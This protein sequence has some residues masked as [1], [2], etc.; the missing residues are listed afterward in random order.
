[1]ARSRK[2][3]LERL[4]RRLDQIHDEYNKREYVNPD[5]LYFLYSY[6][7]PADREVV[8]LIAACLAYGRVEMIM[9]TVAS[10][11]EAMGPSPSAWLEG[12]TREEMD[13]VFDGFCYRFARQEHLTALL[14]GIRDVRERWGSMEACL[15]AG[16]DPGDETIL[17]GLS[18]LTRALDPQGETGHLLAD[19]SK[20]SACKRSHLFLR[21][22]VRKDG[23]DPG[24]WE[25]VDPS[26][27]I[28]PLDT[29]MFK[30]GTFL[31]FTE[32][33]SP[34]RAAALDITAGFRKLSPKDPVKYDFSLTRFGIRRALDMD[35]L[36]TFLTRKNGRLN[37]D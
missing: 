14:T 15:M 30:V 29:H 17:S 7:A 3:G 21:W 33:K 25:D 27:L 9:K 2:I 8:G 28:I 35:D 10:V 16:L 37:H 22:M 36:K 31:D 34:G 1:M 19:P 4:T 12:R 26:R 11:L 6:A 20:T 24:G 13:R 23:V 32:K 5:P 18:H